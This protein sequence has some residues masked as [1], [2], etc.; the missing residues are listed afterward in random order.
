MHAA[1][2]AANAATLVRCVHGGWRG[3]SVRVRVHIPLSSGHGCGD[4]RRCEEQACV[5]RTGEGLRGPG[6]QA[7]RGTFNIK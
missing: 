2:T 7:V 4:A 5:E 3:G 6:G 1:G